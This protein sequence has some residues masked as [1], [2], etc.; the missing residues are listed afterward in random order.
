MPNSE[1][2]VS[3]IQEK[4]IDKYENNVDRAFSL[5]KYVFAL[6]T[7][8]LSVI[9]FDKEYELGHFTEE[10]N[11]VG[12]IFIFLALSFILVILTVFPKNTFLFH[13]DNGK[14][15]L[16]EGNSLIKHLDDLYSTVQKQ[17]VRM[18]F[19]YLLT[20]GTVLIFSNIFMENVFLSYFIWV[21]YIAAFGLLLLPSLSKKK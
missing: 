7:L 4:I 11:K 3:Y 1:D 17:D 8:Y 21:Y 9:S 14:Y 6:T 2:D 15:C 10:V 13:K 19:V 16:L 18:I 12:F 5:L 20:F